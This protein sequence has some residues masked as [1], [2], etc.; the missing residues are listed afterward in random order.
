MGKTEKWVP[1]DRVCG[2]ANQDPRTGAGMTIGRF[3]HGTVMAARERDGKTMYEVA[4]DKAHTD[5][6]PGERLHSTREMQRENLLRNLGI[7]D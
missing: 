4:W 1:G 2:W 6:L 3:R 5:L 7:T